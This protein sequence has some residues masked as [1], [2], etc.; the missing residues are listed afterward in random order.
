MERLR[1]TALKLYSKL[2][3][4]TVCSLFFLFKYT[5][6][7]CL[8][9]TTALVKGVVR[10]EKEAIILSKDLLRLNSLVPSEKSYLVG[11]I[12]E[13]I[14]NTCILPKFCAFSEIIEK[15]YY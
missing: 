12:L 9:T 10:R 7:V 5:L 3:C 14:F 1:T 4:L 8:H 11:L 6:Y 13:N 15:G 2:C